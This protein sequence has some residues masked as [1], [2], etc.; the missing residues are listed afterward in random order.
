M[1]NTRLILLTVSVLAPLAALHAMPPG[2]ETAGDVQPKRVCIDQAEQ[3]TGEPGA[4]RR[5]EE[6]DRVLGAAVEPVPRLVAVHLPTLLAPNQ[7]LLVTD[8]A[9]DSPCASAGIAPDDILHSCNAVPL[10]DS[11][12]LRE[13]WDDID[14]TEPLVLGLIRKGVLYV[15]KLAGPA[16]AEEPPASPPTAVGSPDARQTATARS[17]VIRC[18]DGQI[19][20]ASTDDTIFEVRV[21]TP[22]GGQH[23]F[24]G[25]RGA[26][27]G[28][29]RTLPE[30]LQTYVTRALCDQDPR[31][32]VESEWPSG[33]ESRPR[34]KS[35]P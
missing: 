25:S 29:I 20:I 32:G 3:L 9:P 21:V 27:I 34:G 35:L 1:M 22:D 31:S 8:V 18:D 23:H 33:R 30:R 28:Q 13:R 15:T 12:Q 5:A 16:T 19:A 24:T 4:K 17:V 7:G 26:I 6:A 14:D 10:L 2:L 11:R